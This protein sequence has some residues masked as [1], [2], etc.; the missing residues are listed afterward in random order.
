MLKPLK[1][2]LHKCERISDLELYGHFTPVEFL[3][4]IDYFNIK[5]KGNE[6]LEW[7]VQ[8]CTEQKEKGLGGITCVCLKVSREQAECF[9][10]SQ[11]YR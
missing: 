8:Y 11:Y 3:L 1:I 9:P 5:V 4:L 2:A 10:L 6:R 7:K